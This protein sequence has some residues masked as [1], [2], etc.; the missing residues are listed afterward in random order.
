MR[1]I[2]TQAQ[3]GF[4]LIELMIVVAIIA[5]LAAIAIP[6]YQDYMAR[7]QAGAALSDIRGGVTAFEELIN[8]G[9]DINDP[10][11][12]GLQTATT[13]CGTITLDGDGDGW[14]QCGDIQGNPRVAGQFV[15]LERNSATG[16]WSCD[17]NIDD[18]YA[19]DGCFD[20]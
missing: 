5:I 20:D 15:K 4:T 2:K 13:R 12:I 19:P 11:D 10:S 1:N 8:R 18:Q 16:A 9:R 3:K 14:I 7:S 6:A 17:T